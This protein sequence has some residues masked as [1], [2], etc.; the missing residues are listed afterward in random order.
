MNKEIRV[1]SAIAIVFFLLCWGCASKKAPGEPQV[2]VPT[3]TPTPNLTPIDVSAQVTKTCFV[4]DTCSGAGS[5]TSTVAEN[6][7]GYIWASERTDCAF[8]VKYDTAGNSITSLLA[9]DVWG[10]AADKNNNWIWYS[11]LNSTYQEF[12]AMNSNDFSFTGTSFTLPITNERFCGLGYDGQNLWT[13]KVNDF[14]YPVTGDCKF[15][16]SRYS[17]DGQKLTE[18]ELDTSK[19][20][21]GYWGITYGD[22]YLW[23]SDNGN[24]GGF[25][26]GWIYKFTETGIMMNKYFIGTDICLRGIQWVNANTFYVVLCGGDK[27]CKINY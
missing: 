9:P 19:S 2:T 20:M 6:N 10:M 13:I 12:K 14:S 27:I 4:V 22:G 23:I 18:F 15:W 7:N 1:L 5:G 21:W 16:C 26:G 24:I 8:F 17:T 11:T 3:N 25:D